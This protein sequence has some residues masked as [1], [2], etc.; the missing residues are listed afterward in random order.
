MRTV[1]RGHVDL[2]PA[3]MRRWSH[4]ARGAKPGAYGLTFV[5]AV[6]VL[7]LAAC[8][9]S[10]SNV[11]TTA[12]SAT[13]LTAT[14]YYVE[15]RTRP[16]FT[17]THTFVVYGAQD[18]SGH[19]VETKTIGFYPHGGALGPFIG[20]VA[21][22][23]EVG[24]EDYYAKLQSEVVYH[25]SL[26]TEQYR[27]LTQYFDAERADDKVYNLLFNNCNDFV[28]GAADAV[29]LKVPFVHVLPPP[30]FIRLLAEMNT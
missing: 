2:G 25:R 5:L 19:P 3:M 15:F 26:T 14:P 13:S 6:F 27:R 1:F 16:Y 12:S 17:I 9:P 30:M 11:P 24:Q 7:T 23:G 28:A 22:S 21:I 8:T 10:D 29:G 20:V 4:T 18:S